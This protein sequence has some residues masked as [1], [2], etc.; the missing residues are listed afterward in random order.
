MVANGNGDNVVSNSGLVESS[1]PADFGDFR[2]LRELGR[3]G[4][5]VVY[6]AKQISINRQVA[7]KILPLAAVMDPRHL[8]RFRN[9]VQV[10]ALLQ[11]T[12][13]VPIHSVGNERGIHYYAMQYVEGPTLAEVIAQLRRLDGID[14]KKE[15]PTDEKSK[16]NRINEALTRNFQQ[17]PRAPGARNDNK[18][19]ETHRTSG[20]PLDVPLDRHGTVRRIVQRL[21]RVG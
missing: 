19:I 8:L 3:G 9:E 5:G 21:F 17:I 1:K 12:N 14:D 20:R 11:H 13:I 7:L 4:M 10:V 16:L 6:L 18:T 2:V 15:D